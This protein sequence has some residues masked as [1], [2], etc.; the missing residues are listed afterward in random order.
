L[1][2]ERAFEH[3]CQ[4][5]SDRHHAAAIAFRLE[6]EM[7]ARYASRFRNKR[8]R[9]MIVHGASVSPFVRKVLVFAAEKGLAL[10]YKPIGIGRRS[11]TI[12]K[13]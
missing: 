10:D 7:T 6:T 9:R 3:A 8:I 2:L 5:V 1:V 13:A 11:P 12:S 4:T